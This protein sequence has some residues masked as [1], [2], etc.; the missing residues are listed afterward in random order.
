M[1]YILTLCTALIC[2]WQLRAGILSEC[3]TKM[4]LPLQLSYLHFGYTESLHELDH[5]FRPWQ[6][7]IYTGK[8]DIYC[9]VFHVTKSDTL[10]DGK[11]KAASLSDYRSGQLLY[12]E[13]GADGQVP[14]TQDML[15]EQPYTLAR[16]TPVLLLQHFMSE[17]I[18]ENSGAPAGFAVYK[19]VLNERHITLYIRKSD[20]LLHKISI[21]EHDDLYGDVLSTLY[22]SDYAQLEG[23]LYYP[24]KIRVEKYNGKLTDEIEVH[25]A[26]LREKAPVL[27]TPSDDYALWQPPLPEIN[28]RTEKYNDRIHFIELEHTDDRSLLVEFDHFLLL[29]EAPLNSE[30]GERILAEAAKIAPG[31]PVQYFVFG[32]HHPHYLGGLRAFVHRGARII[33]SEVNK[34]YV[35]YIAGAPHTLQPDKLQQEPQPLKTELIKD[36][37][38]ISEGGYE[39]I[40]YFIGAASQH[41]DDYLL[42]YFPQEKLL[43]QDDLV[44]IAKEGPPAKAGARQEGLYNAIQDLGIPVETI[45]QSWPVRDYGVKTIIPFRELEESVQKK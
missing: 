43:F 28:V 10:S 31:K 30:N 2:T 13:Y 7:S 34:E 35:E 24:R 32:H 12:K 27:L 5:N 15:E 22:Y 14:V 8:G 33:C 20:R 42:Y 38:R 37:L 29:A 1:K 6:A 41:T 18:E 40:I 19:S 36:S 39:M 21:L 25:M 44:W 16:Y 9:S 11:R 4:A 23:Q 17:E 3:Y 45:V 26:E